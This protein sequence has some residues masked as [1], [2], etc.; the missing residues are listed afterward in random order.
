M[1]GTAFFSGYHISD[2]IALYGTV[3]DKSCYIDITIDSAGLAQ[4]QMFTANVAVNGAIY[5]C[6][7]FENQLAVNRHV[8]ID[9]GR[10]GF[11]FNFL[12]LLCQVVLGFE[13]RFN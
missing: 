1:N 2:H 8:L 13:H 5:S 3:T 9:D 4:D 12:E 6:F 7:A 11:I 10:D